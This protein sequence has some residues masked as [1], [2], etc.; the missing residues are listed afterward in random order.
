MEE[1]SAASSGMLAAGPGRR[2][3]EDRLMKPS[4]QRLSGT[5]DWWF[6]RD[7]SW[8]MPSF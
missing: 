2:L 4:L 6:G 5:G 7:E 3:K 1:A 8:L